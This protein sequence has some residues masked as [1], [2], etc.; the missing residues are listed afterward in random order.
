METPP[1]LINVTHNQQGSGAI[2]H[3]NCPSDG[4]VEGWMVS[5]EEANT[6]TKNLWFGKLGCLLKLHGGIE[7]KWPYSSIETD[8]NMQH[9]PDIFNDP[10]DY[11]I[12]DFPEG[13]KLFSVERQ[14][15]GE[16]TPHKDYYLCGMSFLLLS[17]YNFTDKSFRQ[18]QGLQITTRI[19]SPPALVTQ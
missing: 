9:P 1:L 12:S 5:R 14:A 6:Q 7:C 17:M 3:I 19:L 8:T 16:N 18:T 10:W 15:Q 4:R 13:Y 11:K 2:L